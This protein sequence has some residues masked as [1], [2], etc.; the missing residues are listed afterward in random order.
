MA[1]EVTRDNDASLTATIENGIL[2]AVIPAQVMLPLV[3]NRT[4]AENATAHKFTIDPAADSAAAVNEATDLGNTAVNPTS[5]TLTPGEVGIMYT[6]TDVSGRKSLQKVP[7][8]ISRGTRACI[9][10]WETDLTA[11][12]S[13]FTGNTAVG[14]S[15]ADFT[16]GQFQSAIYTLE[17]ADVPGPYVFVGHPIQIADLRSSVTSAGGAIWG[18]ESV[19]MTSGLLDKNIGNTGFKG[20]LLGIDLFASSTCPTANAGADRSGAMFRLGV[21]DEEGA[22]LAIVWSMQLRAELQRDAS[23]RATEIVLVS[24]YAVGEVRDAFGVNVVTDA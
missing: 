1:N 2:A 3:L 19:N 7:Q 23:L 22:A 21:D 24:D 18:N 12:F 16:Y 4:L 17:A 20:E 14:T 6:V 9:K 15:G 5:V 8:I 13:G 11:L 10:K